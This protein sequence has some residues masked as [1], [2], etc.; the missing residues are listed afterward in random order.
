MMR[1]VHVQ[2][3]YRAA[4]MVKI[5]S[6]DARNLITASVHF[7]ACIHNTDDTCR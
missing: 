6:D 7:E 4:W 2:D 3:V 5:V 1:T